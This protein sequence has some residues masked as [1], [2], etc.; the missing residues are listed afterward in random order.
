M[1]NTGDLNSPKSERSIYYLILPNHL[2]DQQRDMKFEPQ[3]VNLILFVSWI[4]M[5]ITNILPD[6]NLQLI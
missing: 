3:G 5:L 4:T 2:G 6:E 1:T